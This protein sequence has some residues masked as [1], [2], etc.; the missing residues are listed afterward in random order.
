MRALGSFL[1]CGAALLPA[2]S[3]P[4]EDGE[5]A[6]EAAPRE[7]TSEA[8]LTGCTVHTAGG[9]FGNLTITPGS[10]LVVTDF[11]ATAYVD[12][13][14][15]A[16]ISLARGSA[17]SFNHLATSVR[18]STAGILDVRDGAAYRAD[19]TVPFALGQPRKIRIAADLLS[20]TFSVYIDL[21][22]YTER[23]A[24]R[25]AFRTT[26]ATVPS[27]DHL[28]AIVDGAAGE[29]SLCNVVASSPTAVQYAREGAYSVVPLLSDSAL[30][31]DGTT[32]TMRLSATGGAGSSVAFGGELAVDPTNQQPYVARVIDTQL[33]LNAY[34]ST[35]GPRWSRLDPIAAGSRV[36][37]AA[38][39]GAGVTLAIRNTGGSISIL[40]YP[41]DGGAGIVL[42]SGGTHAALDANGFAVATATSTAYDVAMFANDGTLQWTQSFPGAI[43]ASIEVMTLGLNGRVVLGGHFWSPITFGGPTL[44][45]AYNGEV[46]VNTYLVGLDRAAGGA[47]V[48]TNRVNATRLTGASGN[49]TNLVVAGERVVT[50]IFPD[51]WRYNA[52]GAQVGV[53]APYL[54]F[55]EGWGRSGRIAMGPSGRVW[56]ERSMVWPTPTSV[57]YPYLIALTP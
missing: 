38:A 49:G 39:D 43:G 18:F 10:G 35:L 56:W 37:S 44:D 50:P 11:D 55:Y 17:T 41:A 31:S 5:K 1:M 3:M 36:L 23:L 15:D 32:I 16:V 12:P 45:L 30:V 20:H 22:S 42:Y 9:G 26:T 27:V 28:A 53:G 29:L 24:K 33:A 7:A 21:G 54:G 34:T 47:H 25:Y 46:N 52:S 48:F 40:R 8:S 14:L 13:A 2:C 19:A 4:D 51:F 6:V 57:P